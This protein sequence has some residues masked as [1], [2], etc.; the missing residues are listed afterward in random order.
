MTSETTPTVILAH[1]AWHDGTSWELVVP[2][3]TAAGVDVVAP[4]YRGQGEGTPSGPISMTG[5]A[6]DVI[7]AAEGSE[8]ACVVV[9]HSMGGFVI[10]V[11][12]QM[13]PELF[14]HLIYLTAFV[15]PADQDCSLMDLS[16]SPELLG[17]TQFDAEAGVTRIDPAGA[18]SVLYNRADRTVLDNLGRYLRPQPLSPMVERFTFDA[19]GL[20]SVP[21]SFIECSD[22][23]AIT[24]DIQQAMQNSWPFEGTVTLD[25]DHMAM[26]STPRETAAAILSLV[27]GAA[28]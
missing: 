12:A 22:D 4:T 18:E 11:A 5:Y 6:E 23:R 9:G 16:V 19:S 27:R 10:S 3:L 20:G 28:S 25:A 7:A 2:E 1:G 21:K 14:S 26:L 17:V 8:T 24:P 15:P 13:R